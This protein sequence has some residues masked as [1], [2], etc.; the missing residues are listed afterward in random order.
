MQHD[1]YDLAE[2]FERIEYELMSSM[3]RN[4]DRHRAEETEEGYNWSMWQAEQLKALEK[5][6]KNNQ[7]KYQKQFK[8]IN[9]QIEEVIRQARQKG[10]MQQEIRILQAIKKGW[11]VHG[12]NKSPA[13]QAMTAEFFKLNDRKLEALIKATRK[14]KPQYSAR[15]MTITGK[16]FLMPRFTRILA[17]ELMRKRWIWL[18]RTCFP[19]G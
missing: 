15:P 17:Q 9:A 2:A 12:K 10:N 3:I 1:E 7:K 19:E 13:H 18:P 8:S 6:K 11:K 4:M 5:Y 14:R 16:P